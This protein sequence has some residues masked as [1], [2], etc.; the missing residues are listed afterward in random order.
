MGFAKKAASRRCVS[1]GPQ[2]H[3][4]ILGDDTGKI[5][6]EVKVASEPEALLQVLGNP[7]HH[8]KW[9][10]LEAGPRSTHQPPQGLTGKVFR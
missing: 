2:S 9:I 3:A 5:V 8:F 6:R 7:I 10:G 4:S 1:L